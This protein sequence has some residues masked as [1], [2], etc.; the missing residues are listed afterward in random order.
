MRLMLVGAVVKEGD[1]I[2]Q[3]V[4]ERVSVLFWKGYRGWVLREREVLIW[5]GR[6]T[7][8]TWSW[9]KSW[10]RVLGA[11]GGL[12]VRARLGYFY[13]YGDEGVLCVGV[14]VTYESCL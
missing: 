11:L 8:R 10:R 4:L 2:A 5:F 14:R 3:L 7:R 12:G 13:G 1:R 6:S 9:W